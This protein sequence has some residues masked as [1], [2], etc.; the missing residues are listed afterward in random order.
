VPLLAWRHPKGLARVYRNLY[1][2]EPG[3]FLDINS[4]ADCHDW[5]A[6]SAPSVPVTAAL[7]MDAAVTLIDAQLE[8]IAR[9][10]A[11]LLADHR[12][13]EP[14]ELLTVAQAAQL[15]GVSTKTIR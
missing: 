6:P 7:T 14:S 13:S 4:T 2:G 1:F 8:A 5:D 3:T 15:A 12:P 10:V 9:R 11:E